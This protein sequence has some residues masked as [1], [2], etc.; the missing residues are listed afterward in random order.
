MNIVRSSQKSTT[1]LDYHF[2]NVL[3]FILAHPNL[4]ESVLGPVFFVV[5]NQGSASYW[6]DKFLPSNELLFV[7]LKMRKS[8]SSSDKFPLSCSHV[9]AF[10]ICMQV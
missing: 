5:R 4:M 6:H 3:F 1:N 2:Y 7:L 9:T 10:A 8:S